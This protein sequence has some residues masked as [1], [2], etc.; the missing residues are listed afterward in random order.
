MDGHL[1]TFSHELRVI[2]SEKLFQI[3]FILGLTGNCSES[4]VPDNVLLIIIFD[5]FSHIILTSLDSNL[6]KNEAN[7]MLKQ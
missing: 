4:L 3:L 7:L 1:S 2:G 5:T 6:P